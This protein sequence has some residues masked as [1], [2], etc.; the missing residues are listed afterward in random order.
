MFQ[1]L[2][3]WVGVEHI[4]QQPGLAQVSDKRV[5]ALLHCHLRLR[6]RVLVVISRKAVGFVDNISGTVV[7]HSAYS[8]INSILWDLIDFGRGGRRGYNQKAAF[9]RGGLQQGFLSNSYPYILDEPRLGRATFRKP[10]IQQEHEAQHQST[11]SSRS[12]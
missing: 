8:D 5:L 6:R 10:V 11:S 2:P 4:F 7:P 3:A 12:V 9:I 1:D